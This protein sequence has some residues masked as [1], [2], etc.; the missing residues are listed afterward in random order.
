MYRL[1]ILI[2]LHLIHSLSYSQGDNREYY[3]LKGN[4]NKVEQYVYGFYK[5]FG[6]LKKGEL[7]N[8]HSDN[9]NL[10]FFSNGNLIIQNWYFGKIICQS[11][12]LEYNN[13]YY[14]E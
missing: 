12:K 9:Y 13:R 1:T 10:E 11:M 7:N 2:L 3:D 14:I 5:I 8:K 6:K 4:V